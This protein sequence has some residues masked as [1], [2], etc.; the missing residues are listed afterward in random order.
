[1]DARPESPF[2]ASLVAARRTPGR[3]AVDLASA[4]ADPLAAYV[5]QAAV[6]RQLGVQVAAWKVGFGPNQQPVGAPIFADTVRPSGGRWPLPAQT[7]LLVELEIAF[8][9][10]RDLPV[11][12]DAPYRRD[13]V[14]AATGEAV[15]GIEFIAGRVGESRDVPFPVWL[16][17]SMGNAGYVAGGATRSL[18]ALDLTALHCRLAVDGRTVHDAVGGH[19]QGDPVEPLRAWASSAA[20][21]LGGLRAGQIVTT[22]S[23]SG[24]LRL[25][26]RARIVGEIE[27]IG[28]VAVDVA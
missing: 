18:R 9:L 8:R 21:R 14:L 24:V 17:D 13:E 1:M 25:Q 12:P 15:A 11:R 4:P 19:P 6:A 16:A 5:A 3:A 22:G 2:V 26:Q 7:P 27:G 28:E 20:D 23:V 10:A